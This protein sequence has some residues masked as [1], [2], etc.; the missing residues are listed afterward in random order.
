LH[1]YFGKK[2]KK[3]NFEIIKENILMISFIRNMRIRYKL[4]ASFI[5]VT[6]ILILIGSIR[7]YN[8]YQLRA[9]QEELASNTTALEALLEL[10]YFVR[11]DLHILIEMVSAQERE[12]EEY[13]FSEHQ[14]QIGFIGDQIGKLGK[15]LG[16][17]NVEARRIKSSS[18]SLYYGSLEPAFHNVIELKRKIN[19]LKRKIEGG[20]AVLT[21]IVVDTIDIP[22]DSL[23]DNSFTDDFLL[24]EIG[25]TTDSLASDL[26][27]ID[28]FSVANETTE[29]APDFS[30]I[31][32]LTAKKSDEVPLT[33]EEMLAKKT[34]E[35]DELRAKSVNDIIELIKIID[36]S[37]Q[38]FADKHVELQDIT[39]NLTDSV[40]EEMIT[41]IVIGLAFA[42]FISIVIS[43]F[44]STSI[45]NVSE[46]IMKLGKGELPDQLQVKSFDELGKITRQINNLSESMSKIAVFANEI[47]QGNFEGKFAPLSDKDV[48]GNALLNM[49]D[50][51][52]K[53]QYDQTLRE[54]EDNIRSWTN[55]GVAK[56]G[57][58]LRRNAHNMENLAN[59]VLVELIKY[60]NSVQGGVFVH[61]HDNEEPYIEMVAS[62][63]FNRKKFLKKN[64]EIGEGLVGMCVLEQKTIHL[65]NI[66]ENYLYITSGLGEAK[67]K[68][69]L[70]VPMIAEG[71]TLGLI[72]LSTLNSF[73]KHQIEFVEKIAE[74]MALTVSSVRIADKT[75]NLL[76]RTQEQTEEMKA[77]EEE[78]RQHM[79]VMLQTQSESE[80][81]QLDMQ[82]NIEELKAELEQYRE[83]LRN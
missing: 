31:T 48:I 38:L 64:I 61:H 58:I 26:F 65:N 55:T 69:L 12:N 77:Q 83:A 76:H 81:K 1:F 11:S 2:E 57:D 75:A 29:P 59:S 15:T 8:V 28:D 56:F 50:S 78:M 25:E 3:C 70:I 46:V 54:R 35:L 79:E 22:T 40:V 53:A 21:E 49:R 72:E 66:P 36:I 51:L 20:E 10:K 14:Q 60:T 68:S 17:D 39:D 16:E 80:D 71:I 5:L 23:A 34:N 67:P 52:K 45:N 32:N 9:V 41:T 30:L 27:S 63:A 24:Q 47:G 73:E 19:E 44:I 62:Y 37:R 18:E 7:S 74:S 33:T 82:R 6:S 4:L 43:S 13:W 42:I